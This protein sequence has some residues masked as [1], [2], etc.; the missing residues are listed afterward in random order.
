MSGKLKMFKE[1]PGMGWKRLS[2]LDAIKP[3]WDEGM[4]PNSS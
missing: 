1:G 4:F 3:L 2:E